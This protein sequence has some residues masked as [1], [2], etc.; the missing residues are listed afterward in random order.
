M[1][2]RLVAIFVN[3]NTG[4]TH[5]RNGGPSGREFIFPASRASL[6][7]T[8]KPLLLTAAAREIFTALVSAGEEEEDPEHWASLWARYAKQVLHVGHVPDEGEQTP[9]EIRE[10]IDRAVDAFAAMHDLAHGL[11][12]YQA[13]LELQDLE[14]I[15]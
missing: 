14:E 12:G 3:G 5:S 6:R 8:F 9:E 7:S 2:T 11:A 1:A 4:V 13:N 15:N 10:W